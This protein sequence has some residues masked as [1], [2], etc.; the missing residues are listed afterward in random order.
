MTSRQPPALRVIIITSGREYQEAAAWAAPTFAR[1][2]RDPREVSVLLPE[3][4]DVIDA[5]AGHS[6][7][8]GFQIE[9]FPLR[10]ARDEMFTSRLK[11]Q[12]FVF[13]VS[14][15]NP[16]ELLLLVDADT[17]CLKPL[18]VPT[19][20]ED[21]ILKGKIGL[22]PDIEDRHFQKETDP[23]YL[24]AEERTTYVNSGV[25]LAGARSLD[26]F[27]TFQE[28]SEQS[29]FLHGPFQD[30]K[31]INFALGKYFRN[32]LVLLDPVYNG[33][34]PVLSTRTLIVHYAGGAGYLGSQ[35]RKAAHEEVCRGT[36]NPAGFTPSEIVQSSSAEPSAHT[37]GPTA[38]ETIAPPGTGGFLRLVHS[39]SR[40]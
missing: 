3:Q 30:Q 8:F 14:C 22:A 26:L 37:L 6:L 10:A 32:R 20:I 5:L 27:K 13:A 18:A 15:L 39:S 35:A 31:V 4:E 17:C 34:N 9:R 25:I 23:W 7:K 36:L 11:C 38:I 1:H 19:G 33:I 40:S 21:E 16:H 28:L 29:L 12:A 2:L 24:V